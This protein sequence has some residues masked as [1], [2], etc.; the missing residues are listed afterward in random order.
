MKL[1]YGNDE[2]EIQ[3]GLDEAGRGSLAGPVFSAAVIWDS[4]KFDE[5]TAQIKDSKKLTKKKR[6]LLREYIELN[7]LSFTVNS[8]DNN[9]IDEINISNATFRSMHM[10]LQKTNVH[11]DRI[12]VDGDRFKPY[13][14][15]IHNCIPQGDNEYISIAAAS[16]LAKTYHDD[17][18]IE[19]CKDNPEFET[20]Y[21][22]LSNM[23]YGTLAHR[24]GILSHGIN[25]YH[26]KTFCTKFL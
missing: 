5:Q 23:A 25:M 15:N 10:C 4:K 9:V 16:I 12:L 6:Y 17:W 8:C 13:M 18:I 1:F 19:K 3:I 21:K 14:C 20:K 7:A 11:F 22:W 26:R 24:Q 2:S